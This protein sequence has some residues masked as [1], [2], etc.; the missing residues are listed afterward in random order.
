MEIE[1][2]QSHLERMKQFDVIIIG[3]GLGGLVCGYILGKNGY[4]VGIFEKNSQIGGCLQ[5]FK[6][7]GVGFDTGMHYIG[8]MEEGQILHRFFRYLDLL[9]DVKLM[10]L[11]EDGFDHIS[12]ANKE[13]R[14]AM[15]YERFIDELSNQF[16]HQR[17]NIA[18][19]VK[20]I[21]EIAEASPL[22]NLREINAP[23]F[24]ETYYIKS[25]VSSFIKEITTDETLRNV[26]A[27][28]N[29]LYAGVP[30]K[31]PLYIHALINNF[32][33]QSAWRIVGGSDSISNSLAKSIRSFG[34]EIFTDA[35]VK[36]II[37]STDSATSIE[38]TNG[39]IVNGKQFISNIHPQSTLEKLDSPLIRRVYRERIGSL[40]NTI[41][42]FTIYLIFK[43]GKVKYLNYNL[44]KHNTSDVWNCQNYTQ[45]DWPRNFLYMHQAD[46]VK[47]D[48]AKSAQAI[49]YMNYSEVAQWQE[50]EVGKRGTDYLSFKKIKAERLLDD[51]EKEFPGIRDNIDSYYTS[52]PLTY[53]NYT[54]TKEGSTYGILRDCNF[55]TQT[56]VS[57]RTKIP[58]LF[59]TGQNIN[60]HG[61]L[62]VTIGAII[63][64][65]E[66][67]GINKVIKEINE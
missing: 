28:S 24:I 61:I 56:L 31:T 52:S 37:T 14:Y 17:A 50:S 26:L 48:Y 41:S 23:T 19:Y 4:K 10:K 2:I 43:P 15:G 65:A 57:Q 34:G 16:P 29:S 18:E 40:E 27:G 53:K 55:P 5:T 62:G 25:S 20:K 45:D 59:L 21:K 6:R 42:T 44:Y 51:L 46:S 3:S 60:S 8:S 63:T 38:L 30:D 7:K 58:N 9:N 12:F 39:E 1:T 64:C 54:A 32:Y 33:I 66:F 36:K 13:Y 11:D 49:A 22:Y 35:E 47:M 67:L